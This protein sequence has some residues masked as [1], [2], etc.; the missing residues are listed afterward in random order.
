VTKDL[1][2]QFAHAVRRRRNELGITQEELAWRAGMHRTYLAG[3]EAGVR[4]PSLK[5]IGKLARAL[6]V[7]L[8]GFF[9]K[10][11]LASGT[12]KPPE[13]P[14]PEG[15]IVDILLVEDNPR[16]VEL[17]LRALTRAGLTNR[18]HVA[19]DGADA[20]NCIF[21]DAPGAIHR[22]PGRPHLILLDLNLPRVSGLEVLR[23]L[24]SD[25]Q[26]RTIPVAVLTV[27]QRDSD[28][29]ESRR[30][31]ADAYIVKPVDFGGLSEIAPHL[32]LRW[33]LLQPAGVVPVA[34]RRPEAL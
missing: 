3:I 15:D 18:V 14:D 5:N 28:V 12:T 21:G 13:S 29:A 32:H 31:G 20:L 4:N 27:S 11:E 25:P 16:D 33:A 30:L 23:R 22:R 26:T 7:S 24:K 2:S 6:E 34:E 19:R 8:A 9:A 17:T 1:R 10:V